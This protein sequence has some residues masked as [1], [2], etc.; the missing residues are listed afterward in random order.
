MMT[1]INQVDELLTKFERKS[2]QEVIEEWR[3]VI[4]GK[5]DERIQS[6]KR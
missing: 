2:T 4:R 5:N 3:K 6:R 1:R